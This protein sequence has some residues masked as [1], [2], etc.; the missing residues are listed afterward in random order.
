MKPSPGELILVFVL[1]IWTLIWRGLSLWRSAKQEQ[2]NWFIALLVLG[3]F[4]NILGL[5]DI[6]YLFRFSKKRM[7]I[8]E[9]KSGFQDIFMNKSKSK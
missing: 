9:I 6:I 4:F 8:Q 5:L 1:F 3:T 2:Q 7:T